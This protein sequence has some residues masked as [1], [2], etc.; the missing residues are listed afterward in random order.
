M[1]KFK[2]V[3]GRVKFRLP[4]LQTEY[5]DQLIM[6]WKQEIDSSDFKNLLKKV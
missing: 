3:G 1:R 2:S 6:H 5:Y 4:K